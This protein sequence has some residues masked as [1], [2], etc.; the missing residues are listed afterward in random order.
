LI[1]RTVTFQ[2][3]IYLRLE[4]LARIKGVP[5]SSIIKLACSEYLE[6]ESKKE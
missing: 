1:K 3:D 6:K 4:E 2:K 5:V